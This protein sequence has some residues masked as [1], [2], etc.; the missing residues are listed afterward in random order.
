LIALAGW[1]RVEYDPSAGFVRLTKPML[2]RNDI[3][4]VSTFETE[5]DSLYS[6][7]ESNRAIMQPIGEWDGEHQKET[8]ASS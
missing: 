5:L 8:P 2:T 6:I 7:G 4:D 1:T 3:P